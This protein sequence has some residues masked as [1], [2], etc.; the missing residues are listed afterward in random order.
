MH[1]TPKGQEV[2]EVT[3]IGFTLA[4]EKPQRRFITYSPQTPA[5]LNREVFRIPAGDPN[6]ESPAVDGQFN[7]DAELVWFMP[8]MH[9]RGKDMSYALTYPDG[10]NEI[11]LRVAR[12]N[13]AWQPGYDAASPIKVPKGAKLHVSAHYDNSANNPFNPNPSKDVYGGAQDWEEMMAPF[14]GVV[15]DIGV[16]PRKVITLPGQIGPGGE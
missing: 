4:K 14:F 7:V 2:T 13:P 3:R 16:D 11:L 9:L 5:I 10:R 1:Y 12:Y 8:H 6:W 15:V